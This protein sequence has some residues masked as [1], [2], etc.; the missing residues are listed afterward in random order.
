MREQAADG[1]FAEG[2]FAADR[3]YYRAV[4]PGRPAPGATWCSPTGSPSTAAGTTMWPTALL[5]TRGCPYGHPTIGA[6]AGPR[7]R[8]PTSS[9]SGTRGRRS[10][11]VCGCGAGPGPGRSAVPRRTFPGRPDRDGLR[12]APP[13]PAHRAGPFG[14][15]A[16]RRARGG[17]SRR[18][19][20]DPGPGPGRRHLQRPRGRPGLQGRSP[21]LPGSSAAAASYGPPGRSRRS[22]TGLARSQ[23][24]VTR[25][26]RQCRP[27]GQSRRR[28][29]TS[30]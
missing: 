16:P 26:A 19:R 5:E 13:R 3:L 2:R 22:A 10:Q 18:T 1:H 24:A 4:E 20:G 9:R 8:E 7:G 15:P 23:P 11:P 27:P 25:H 21:G 6:M 12:R 29:R 30:S 17:G 28:S 14:C